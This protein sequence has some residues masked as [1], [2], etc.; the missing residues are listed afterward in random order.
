MFR[1]NSRWLLF[2]GQASKD[3]NEASTNT[4]QKTSVFEKSVGRS[5][6]VSS[7]LSL[8]RRSKAIFF[9]VFLLL[10]KEFNA[11]V[12]LKDTRENERSSSIDTSD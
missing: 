3:R 4:C 1:M 6:A 5:V 12:I 10:E 9:Q 7:W 11:G 8:S 2:V